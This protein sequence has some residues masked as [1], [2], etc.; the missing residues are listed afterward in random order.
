MKTFIESNSLQIK[1]VFSE[2]S[3]SFHRYPKYPLGEDYYSFKSEDKVS[4]QKL[5]T[6][7]NYSSV[8]EPKS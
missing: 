7:I 2:N 4:G 5:T 3:K 8:I 6:E 1:Q